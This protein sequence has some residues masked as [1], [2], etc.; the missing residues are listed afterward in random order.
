MTK[1]RWLPKETRAWW[2]KE[3][4]D[5]AQSARRIKR[6]AYL[7]DRTAET[8]DFDPKL[9]QWYRDLAKEEYRRA[10]RVLAH[11]Q[12]IRDYLDGKIGPWW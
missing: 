6:E 5:F 8:L 3:M 10:Q 1:P 12:Q 11:S 7:W 4:D 2:E 9:A